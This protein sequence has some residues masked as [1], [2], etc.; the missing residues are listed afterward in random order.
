MFP[1]LNWLESVLIFTINQQY[2]A[3]L[4]DLKAWVSRIGNY[5][6]NARELVSSQD[7]AAKALQ[8]VFSSLF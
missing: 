3:M 6:A 1:L 7:A 8:W 2:P 5:L 4:C